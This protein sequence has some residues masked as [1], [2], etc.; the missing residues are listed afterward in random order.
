MIGRARTRLAE[1]LDRRASRRS[2]RATSGSCPDGAALRDLAPACVRRAVAPQPDP[3]RTPPDPAAPPRPAPMRPPREPPGQPVPGPAVERRDRGGR[4]PSGGARAP[5]VLELDVAPG[6]RRSREASDRLGIAPD[7]YVVALV[8]G[9]GSGSPRSSTRSAAGRQP[10]RR[11][12]PTTDAPVA[13]VADGGRRASRRS[14]TARAG[15]PA[16]RTIGRLAGVVI[17]DLPD[18]DSLEAGAPGDRRCA[19]RSSTSSPGSPTRRSTPTPPST[20]TSF[21]LDAA[22]GPP[23]RGPQQGRPAGRRQEETVSRDLRRVLPERCPSLRPGRAKGETGWPL[24]NWLAGGGRRQ[25]C[26]R[27]SAGRR[28]RPRGAARARRRGRRDQAAPTSWSRSCRRSTSAGRPR[29]RSRRCCGSSTSRARAAGRCRHPGAGPTSRHGPD[30]DPYSLRS[31]ASRVG[32]AR[33]PIPPSTSVAGVEAGWHAPRS[34][35]G[36]QSRTPCPACRLASVPG[37]PP[38]RTLGTWSAGSGRAR[39]VI[40]RHSDIEAPSSRIW[41]FVGLLQAA[42]T[43]LLIFAVAWVVL[44]VIARPEVASYDLPV[45]G[46][47]AAPMVLLFVA[48]AGGYL[49]ARLLSIH[50]GWVGGAGRATLTGEVRRA[51]GEVIDARRSRRSP[52]SRPRDAAR[53]SA[54]TGV[55][56]TRAQRQCGDQGVRAQPFLSLRQPPARLSAMIARKSAT[57]ARSLIGSPWRMRSSGRSRCRGRR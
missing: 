24:R 16:P 44:W 19:C 6:P 56:T 3:L 38:P 49:I 55:P 14:W 28:R 10:R 25:G 57:I 54:G 22:A 7:T 37:T 39:S 35:S 34:S 42:N 48:L 41:P 27:R 5:R 45:L 50:A 20:T 52:A 32:S 47:V 2:S 46:P 11:R 23:D 9:P 31:T 4:R 30:R 8:G 15:E 13:W 33:S 51:V 1:A 12:R 36:A 26:R 21:E 29:A 40:A 18:V 43:L 53:G 17:L